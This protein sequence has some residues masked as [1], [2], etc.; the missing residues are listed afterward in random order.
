MNTWEDDVNWFTKTI[1]P[2][3]QDGLKNLGITEEPP[4]VVRAHDTNCQ[5]VMEAAL[6]LYK[7][8]YTMNKYN[9]ESLCTYE[10]RGPWT[11]THRY[12]SSLGSVHVSNVH[13]LAN[14]EPFRYGS[15]DFIQKSVLFICTGNKK[16][17]LFGCAVC[18]WC[19]KQDLNLHAIAS[20]RT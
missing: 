8:L 2:G 9:G 17:A 6:P 11:E 10:P 3:V 18:R 1:I 20:I 16:A 5:M 7:N 4:I 19:E 12:L 13:I 15:P 14:L